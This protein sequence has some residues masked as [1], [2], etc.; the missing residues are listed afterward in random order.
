MS[1]KLQHQFSLPLWRF[2]ATVISESLSFS[3]VSAY[4]IHISNSLLTSFSALRYGLTTLTYPC[5]LSLFYLV[6]PL[7][8]YSLDQHLSRSV[9]PPSLLP[10]FIPY[11]VSPPSYFSNL[12]YYFTHTPWTLLIL[13]S[14]Q[15]SPPF[16]LADS[17]PFHPTLSHC[18]NQHFPPLAYSTAAML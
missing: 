2:A 12:P 17:F 4:H 16:Q 6:N 7:P 13:F 1:F 9:F 18:Q 5:S 3:P 14:T 8:F 15:A 11:P 10:S